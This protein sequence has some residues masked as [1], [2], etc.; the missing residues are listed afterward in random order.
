[1][2]DTTLYLGIDVGMTGGLAVMRSDGELLDIFRFDGALVTD[3]LH[4]VFTKYPTGISVAIEQI[5]CRP[6]Q[7]VVSVMTFGPG[8]GRILGFLEGRGIPYTL[9]H[10]QRW[11]SALPPAATAK[12]RA[13]KWAFKTYT[14]GR[15]IF[16]KCRTPHQGCI[17][18]TGTADYHRSIMTGRIKP[19]AIRAPKIRRPEVKF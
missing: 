17:D 18:A 3:T 14:S 4:A 2:V 19:K 8:Y 7:G 1:M 10:P 9:Y 15:F 5:G 11:Q 12:D 16:P 13:K 6:S